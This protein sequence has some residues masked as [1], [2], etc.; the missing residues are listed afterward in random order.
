MFGI[1]PAVHEY[2]VKLTSCYN[3]IICI[4]LFCCI[5]E[6]VSLYCQ[7]MLDSCGDGY[8]NVTAMPTML[9]TTAENSER[10][11]SA[12]VWVAFY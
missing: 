10:S 5:L 3:E 11:L 2:T 6:H 8:C 12:A 9:L 1:Y 4:F 7:V